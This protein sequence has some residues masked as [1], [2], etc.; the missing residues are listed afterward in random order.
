MTF[1]IHAP[2]FLCALAIAPQAIGRVIPANP[3]NYLQLAAKLRTG[4]TL[5][6]AA[7]KYLRGLPLRNLRG[8]PK[9]PIVIRG[10]GEKT[11]LLGR[12][13]SNTMDISDC[14][15]LE[16]R[17]LTFDGR[18]IRN[19]D[20]IKAGGGSS[21][22]HHVTIAN[23]LI[24]GHGGTQQACGIS[25]KVTAWD[26]VI[27]DN[28]VIGA[29]TGL[30]LGN[31]DG[32]QPFIRGLVQGNLVKN[33]KGYCMQIKRQNRRP[34]KVKGIPKEDTRTIIRY[35]VF[36]KDDGVGDSG[37]RPNLLV[38]AFP[39]QGTGS[40]DLYEIYGN[41]FWHNH[42]ESLFQGT[43]RISLHDNLFVDTRQNA[44]RIM[45]HH[46]R[47]PELVRIYH[48]TFVGV[49]RAI[50]ATGMKNA[51]VLVHFGNLHADA[52]GRGI[53]RNPTIAFGK[54][55]PRPVR[56]IRDNISSASLQAVRQDSAHAYD[57]YGNPKPTSL[58]YQGAYAPGGAKGHSIQERR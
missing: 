35:N 42:R 32:E 5:V 16:I 37:L 55:D 56:A 19:I 34:L 45:N 23:N 7:G 52:M 6:L 9:T 57:F 14:S 15:Y 2:L 21:G 40:R 8:Q 24:R 22:V 31:S 27:R 50:N 44:I 10:S 17:N 18:N 47:P 33:P 11:I 25:T 20:A 48:N 29:G 13:G 38:G 28:V 46:G 4:D 39:P 58:S 12:S 36:I 51:S 54:L 41:V 53:L 3:S 43:G 30:Y 26:W 1:P 49:N